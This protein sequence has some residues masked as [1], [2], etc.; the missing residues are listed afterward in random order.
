MI[1]PSMVDRLYSESH[2]YVRELADRVRSIL[3]VYCRENK[4]LYEDRI[5]T[6]ESTA[7]KLETGRYRTWQDL[8]DLFAASIV[9]PLIT[10]EKAV[11]DF[12]T[13]R[14]ERV[15]IN[16]RGK[17]QKSPD[18]FRFDSTR[19]VGRL[20]R[21]SGSAEGDVY[22]IYSVSFEVQVK[23][24]FD[25]AWTRTTHALTYKGPSVSWERQRLAAQ[26]KAAAEQMDMLVLGFDS[27]TKFAGAGSW[28]G[29]DDR[30][31]IEH[32][33]RERVESGAIPRELVPKD[34]TRFADNAYRV[35]QIFGGDPPTGMGQRHLKRLDNLLDILNRE[36]T[37]LG[38]DG[39]PR[40]I[41]LLQFVVGVLGSANLACPKQNA[42][43]FLQT[44]EMKSLF[45][46]AIIPGDLFKEGK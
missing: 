6:L 13:D 31:K 40:S 34:W 18:T 27:M 3:T 12:L 16:L 5:K 42:F 44:Q 10:E 22:S 7:E 21:E 11:V 25:F 38:P 41:S 15:A 28:P 2:A 20:P 19:F 45:P 1:V 8:D 46:N 36:I 29:T 14:F 30:A 32:F 39:I 9:I 35:L 4:Y 26:L 43:F 23:T 24:V 33:L 37:K 17:S